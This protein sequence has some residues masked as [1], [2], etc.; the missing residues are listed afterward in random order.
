MESTT[1]SLSNLPQVNESADLVLVEELFNTGIKKY[2]ENDLAGSIEIYKSI[3][4][5]NPEITES[6]VNL[7]NSYFKLN[8]I[9][10]AVE[11]W[12]KALS[13]DSSQV[14]CYVNIGNAYYL[15]NKITEAISKWQIAL[16]IM[17][18]HFNVLRNIAAAYEKL[19]NKS[20]SFKYYE[21]FLTYCTDRRSQDYNKIY[22]KVTQS[23]SIALNCLRTGVQFQKVKNLRAATK[24]YLKAIEMYPLYSKAYLNLGSICYLSSKYEHAI[25]YWIESIKIEPDYSNTYFNIAIAL[26]KLSKFTYAYCMYSRY[27][28]NSKIKDNPEREA[29]N[30]RLQK[31]QFL[32]GLDEPQQHVKNGDKFFEQQKYADALME[33][34]NYLILRPA[35]RPDIDQKIK[36]VRDIL[37]PERTAAKIA[38]DIGMS[39]IEQGKHSNALQAFKRYLLFE[40]NGEFANLAQEK[41]LE[42]NQGSSSKDL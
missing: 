34:E 26:E 7:G 37:N 2:E 12:E 30:E 41:I 29:V 10:E 13:L 1:E 28:S 39:C 38:F 15:N 4:D 24:Y 3:I 14:S 33:Y 18:N 19:G 23:R 5:S 17:P 42:I 27:L 21:K 9:D 8:R 31:L 11:Q 22:E 16:T 35:N 25:K 6:Y 36:Q 40:P 20:N 32:I